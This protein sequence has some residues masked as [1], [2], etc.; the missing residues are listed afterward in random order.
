MQTYFYALADYIGTQLNANETYLA[1]L[2]AEE[3]DFIRFNKSVV[4]QA[5]SVKQIAL[6]LSLIA[7]QRRAEIKM[8]LSGNRDTDQAQVKSALDM[9]RVDLAGLPEDPYLLYATEVNS[10]E[11][12][13]AANLPDPSQVLDEVVAAGKGVDLV[14]LYAGGP[15]YRGFANSLGQRNWHRADNFN[16]EWCLYHAA[17]KAVKSS[18]AGSTWETAE[19]AGKME[20]ARQQL[21]RLGDKPMELKPGRYRA[22]FTPSAVNEVL[23]MLCWGGF[24]IKSQRTKQSCLQKMIEDGAL[25]NP[26]VSVAENTRDGIACGFQQDGFIKND[27]V[28]L[29]QG[30]K[31]SDALIS[32]RSAK[33]FSLATNGANSAESPESLDMSGGKLLSKD[34]LKSLDTG[35]LIGNLWYLNFSDRSACRMTGMTRFATFWVENGEIKAPLNVMRFDDSAYRMLG[36][37]LEA[38]TAECDLLPSSDSYGER[39]TVSTRLPGALVK[40]FSLTL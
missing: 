30:G 40:D 23:G 38:L 13:P 11:H 29:I 2:A 12:A 31:L 32:P 19:Y 15:L 17:D 21:A 5:T 1:W 3:S 22:Y 33:E 25:L 14:G 34:A 7:N 10:S 26:S 9:L 16:F 39:S 36:D 27:K 37:N 35:L 6:T 4:R 20:F 28:G 18:Y 24:G 8:M